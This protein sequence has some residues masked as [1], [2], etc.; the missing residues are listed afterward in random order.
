MSRIVSDA[1][2]ARS[3]PSLYRPHPAH[4]F[5]PPPRKPPTPPPPAIDLEIKDDENEPFK[6]GNGVQLHVGI[7]C[8]V[9]LS[10][11]RARFR[12]NVKYLGHL[13]NESGAWVGLEVDDLERFGVETLPT[14]AKDGVRYFYF[15][16]PSTV[17]TDSEAKARR[18]RRIAAIAE[19]LPTSRKR[20]NG[21]SLSGIGGANSL[22][23][24]KDPR[25]AASPFVADWAPPEKPRALFVRPHE[26]V[27][28]MGAE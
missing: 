3:Q 21:H 2:S 1:S 13:P 23:P 26:V 4:A 6:P 16:K 27:F 18:Q 15:T 25:R 17:A 8:I 22:V 24:P 20:F 12:A 5:D 11:R 7:P 28:V 14:G 19:S 9:T 10:Q